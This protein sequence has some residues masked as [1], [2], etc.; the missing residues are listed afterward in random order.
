MTATDSL[1]IYF[2]LHYMYI[3][4]ICNQ[5]ASRHHES[6]LLPLLPLIHSHL[7]SIPPL[8]I[9]YLSLSRR[10]FP[11]IEHTCNFDTRV[12]YQGFYPVLVVESPER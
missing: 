11:P 1:S 12:T 5:L 4:Q 6:S 10:G 9:T 2:A 3:Y 7:P 8:G